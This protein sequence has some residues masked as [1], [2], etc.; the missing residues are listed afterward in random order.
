MIQPASI[1]TSI[2]TAATLV[3]AMATCITPESPLIPDERKAVIMLAP[4]ASRAN[5]RNLP[6]DDRVKYLRVMIFNARDGSIA[7]NKFIDNDSTDYEIKMMTGIYHFVFIANERPE[8]ASPSSPISADLD[9]VRAFGEL[10]NIAFASSDVSDSTLIPMVS[11]YRDVTVEG[12]NKLKGTNP[13]NSAF[14][15]AGNAWSIEVER[16]AIRVDLTLTTTSHALAAAFKHVGIS[17]IPDKVP[18]LKTVHSSEQFEPERQIDK[19]AGFQTTSNGEWVW[20]HRRIILPASNIKNAGQSNAITFTARFANFPDLQGT[21]VDGPTPRNKHYELVG[22]LNE[23]I[24]FKTEVKDWTTIAIIPQWLYVD[25]MAPVYILNGKEYKIRIHAEYDWTVESGDR[26]YLAINEKSEQGKRGRNQWISFN[27]ERTY[28]NYFDKLDSTKISLVFNSREAGR[29]KVELSAVTF[30]RF[31][32]NSYMLKP[33]GEKVDI[34]LTNV[35]HPDILSTLNLASPRLADKE[36]FDVELLWQDTPAPVGNPLSCI[37]KIEKTISGTVNSS[38]ITVTSGGVEGNAVVALR[39]QKSGKILWSWHIWVTHYDPDAIANQPTPK[40]ENYL[41]AAKGSI[42]KYLNYLYMDRF[43]GAVFPANN[44]GSP[45]YIRSQNYNEKTLTNAHLLTK[46]SGYFYQWGRKDPM[47]TSTVSRLRDYKLDDTPVYNSSG[48]KINPPSI[49]LWGD[50]IKVSIEYPLYML[51][52]SF[53]LETRSWGTNKSKNIFDPCPE[54]WRVPHSPSVL[55][56]GPRTIT[57]ESKGEYTPY[58]GYFPY[59]GHRAINAFAT[60]TGRTQFAISWTGQ[61]SSVMSNKEYKAYCFLV[62]SNRVTDGNNDTTYYKPNVQIHTKN[63]ATVRCV[64][65]R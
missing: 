1:S 3:V 13:D 59:A 19:G 6:L 41:P 44:D 16:A 31:S 28:S 47:L 45:Q 48:Q 18:L 25:S 64:K 7:F 53:Y 11:L 37:G 27:L 12:N 34:A 61:I 21:L 24:N 5:G 65:Y 10:D 2:L 63:A 22:T 30:P 39:K 51:N 42:Y 20:Q 29:K 60:T 4:P 15:V 14:A 46:A 33:N 56:P 35:N 54:G 36:D 43:L 32:A 8:N 17:N 26:T 52:Y 40:E 49:I 38:Y 23:K 58:L 9:K 57:W 50:S 55:P 62:G